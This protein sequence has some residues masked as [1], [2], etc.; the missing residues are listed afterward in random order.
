MDTIWPLD[1]WTL[2]YW[3][4]PLSLKPSA[5]HGYT[6]P[7]LNTD[8]W[9]VL[10]FPTG[11]FGSGLF[12]FCCTPGRKP[13]SC[14][15]DFQV[16][17]PTDFELRG[18]LGESLHGRFSFYCLSWYLKGEHFY[19]LVCLCLLGE[20]SGTSTHAEKNSQSVIIWSKVCPLLCWHCVTSDK[21]CQIKL[22]EE[23]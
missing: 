22:S 2:I 17:C 8:I 4:F 11:G 5:F 18:L 12:A 6:G 15:S 3:N 19:L 23:I 13:I 16:V 7:T 9:L 1:I 20:S 14:V 10:N 21:W